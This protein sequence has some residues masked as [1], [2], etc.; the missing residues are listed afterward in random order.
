MNQADLKQ[1]GCECK[2][3]EI[4][5]VFMIPADA[6]ISLYQFTDQLI[7][8]VESKGWHFSGVVSSRNG[9]GR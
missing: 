2:N 3:L 7:E 1:T 6:P 9:A 4:S 8:W 5:G